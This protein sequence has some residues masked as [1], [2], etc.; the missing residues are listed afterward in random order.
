HVFRT[1]QALVYI[2]LIFSPLQFK[3]LSL[4]YPLL[5]HT[6][7]P[8]YLLFALLMLRATPFWTRHPGAGVCLGLCVDIGAAV[9]ASLA[10]PEVRL[11]VT[12]M[13]VVSLGAGG[14][15]LPLRLALFF[16]AVATLSVLARGVLDT[17]AGVDQSS[18]LLESGLFGLAYFAS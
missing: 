6:L 11:G 10:M 12:M 1:C 9:L 17:S 4:Q 5:G 2:L 15:L 18:R 13:L 14:L 7:A 8:A 16:A 3:W